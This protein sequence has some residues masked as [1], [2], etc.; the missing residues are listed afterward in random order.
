MATPPLNTPVL[1]N[2]AWS[3][4]QAQSINVR[5]DQTLRDAIASALPPSMNS[6]RISIVDTNGNDMTN[7]LGAQLETGTRVIVSSAG[8]FEGG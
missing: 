8:V 7:L 5:H 4:G 3:E 6:D 1:V 2:F